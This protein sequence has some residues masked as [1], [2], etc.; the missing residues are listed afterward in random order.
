MLAGLQAREEEGMPSA[1]GSNEAPGKANGHIAGR[2][3][4]RAQWAQ[5][6]AW[7]CR[8]ATAMAVV[9]SSG[10][11]GTAEGPL[12][13]CRQP[14]DCPL[15]AHAPGECLFISSQWHAVIQ[16]AYLFL[17]WAAGPSDGCSMGCSRG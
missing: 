17:C 5:R 9:G 2:Q 16:L 4:Q 11:G 13:P 7:C 15:P 3:Q 10:V 8:A 6:A 12:R 14:A 1:S